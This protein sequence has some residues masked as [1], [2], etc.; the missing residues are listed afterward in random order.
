ML[1]LI[2]SS[3]L[4]LCLLGSAIREF[5][6]LVCS[7]SWYL[8]VVYIC[9]QTLIKK[10]AFRDSDQEV[11]LS[12]GPGWNITKLAALSNLTAS[13]RRLSSFE[14]LQSATNSK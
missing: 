12:V 7:F 9:Q 1:V 8:C 6:R 3:T 5:A 11:L 4:G 10:V 13:L 14:A 2:I